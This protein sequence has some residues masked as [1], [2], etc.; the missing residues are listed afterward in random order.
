MPFGQVLLWYSANFNYAIFSTTK[1]KLTSET[2]SC[3]SGGMERVE[4]RS[5]MFEL[6]AERRV[7]SSYPEP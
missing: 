5:D 4:Y 1:D 7:F 3:R 6:Y 2:L